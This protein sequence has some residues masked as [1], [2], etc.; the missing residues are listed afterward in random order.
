MRSSGLGQVASMCDSLP[1]L[2]SVDLLEPRRHRCHLLEWRSN[3]RLIFLNSFLTRLAGKVQSYSS[4]KRRAHLSCFLPAAGR[5]WR[6]PPLWVGCTRDSKEGR[7]PGDVA[8]LLS[9]GCCWNGVTL[10]DDGLF[11]L[12][13]AA[14]VAVEAEFSAPLTVW[15][16]FSCP[17][18]VLGS[19]VVF[20]SCVFFNPCAKPKY[21]NGN[22]STFLKKQTL[23]YG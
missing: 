9:V 11:Y 21:D 8:A 17:S 10:V 14:V 16:W 13:A 4:S 5:S 6:A 23:N 15:R 19:E 20:K 22:S 7:I 18:V 12:P 3:I 2:R 1:W